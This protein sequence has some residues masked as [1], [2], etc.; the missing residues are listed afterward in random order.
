M[1]ITEFVFILYGWQKVYWPSSP[2]GGSLEGDDAYALAF[3]TNFVM[4]EPMIEDLGSA[5]SSWYDYSYV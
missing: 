4:F 2:T 3:L 5:G 1:H